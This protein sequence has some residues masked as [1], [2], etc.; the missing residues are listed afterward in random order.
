MLKFRKMH[1]LGNDFVIVDARDGSA[2]LTLEQIRQICDRRRG[3]G[4]DLL[5]IL[6]PSEK[7]DVRAEFYNADGSESGTCGNATRCVAHLYMSGAGV[8]SCIVDTKGGLLSCRMAGDLSV[9][10]DMEEPQS[11]EEH[12][13]PP[14]KAIALNMG[15]PHCVFFVDNVQD[16]HVEK[17]GA[18]IETHELFPERSNVEFAQILSPERIRL[19]VWER[20]CGIT[21][22]C[23]SGACATIV[24]A[25]ERGLTGRKAEIIMD[26]GILN[27]E[28]RESDN[29]VLMTGPV[30]YVFDGTLLNPL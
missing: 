21:E 19:R 17:L 13:L 2:P 15:N 5:T 27:L 14:G 4:C 1:G 18:E 12:D 30:A 25:V 26:G 16:I 28:Y 24:S 29:H 23:G 8:D 22:A 3:V 20:G 6:K 10:V 9:E 7:G 11:I